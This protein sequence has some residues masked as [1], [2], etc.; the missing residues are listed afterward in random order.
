[1]GNGN[2]ILLGYFAAATEENTAAIIHFTKVEMK[3][4]G[5]KLHSESEYLLKTFFMV[6]KH[7]PIRS[8][9]FQIVFE[10]KSKPYQN[11]QTTNARAKISVKLGGYCGMNI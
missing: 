10:V 11:N 6:A 9:L 7:F 4:H 1:M 3:Q 8:C 5:I 2:W